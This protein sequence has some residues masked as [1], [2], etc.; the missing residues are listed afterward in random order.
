MLIGVDDPP[1]ISAVEFDVVY[2]HHNLQ[3]FWETYR[4]EDYGRAIRERLAR[5]ERIHVPFWSDIFNYNRKM[6]AENYNKGIS[7]GIIKGKDYK[8]AEDFL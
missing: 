1:V 6:A 3:D 4:I 2:G 7:E 8:T 5:K